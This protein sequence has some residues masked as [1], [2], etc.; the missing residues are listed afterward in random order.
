VEAAKYE[1]WSEIISV[2]LKN[3]QHPL[4]VSFNLVHLQHNAYTTTALLARCLL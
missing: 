4:F 3:C 1:G 2:V